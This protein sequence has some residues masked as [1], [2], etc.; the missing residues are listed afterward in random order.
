MAFVKVLLGILARV[1]PLLVVGSFLLPLAFLG[2]LTTARRPAR[3]LLMLGG[4]ILITFL[5]FHMGLIQLLA[6]RVRYDVRQFAFLSVPVAVLCLCEPSG[7]RRR[8]LTIAVGALV[9][10]SADSYLLVKTGVM[11]GNGSAQEA[12]EQKLRRLMASNWKLLNNLGDK[13]EV[14]GEMELSAESKLW[15]GVRDTGSDMPDQLLMTKMVREESVPAWHSFF[16]SLYWFRKEPR[17]VW[18][19]GGNTKEGWFYLAGET[20]EEGKERWEKMLDEENPFR[21]EGPQGGEPGPPP[22]AGAAASKPAIP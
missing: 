11:T 10:L 15:K 16:T 14:Y 8:L 19:S 13:E 6:E 12:G 18:W 1:H 9:V 17:Q 20:P 7:L 21:H 5:L 3:S 2:R 22:A 4:T